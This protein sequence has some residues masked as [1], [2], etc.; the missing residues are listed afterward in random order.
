MARGIPIPYEQL[1]RTATN[2][3]GFQK[4]AGIEGLNTNNSASIQAAGNVAQ[5]D[6]RGFVVAEQQVGS[7]GKAIAGEGQAIMAIRL[8]QNEAINIRKEYEANTS[9]EMA[10]DAINADLALE[11]D[12]TKWAGIADKHSTRLKDSLLKQDL[13]PDARDAISMKMDSWQRRQSLAVTINSA[14]RS[15][16]KMI[17]AAMAEVTQLVTSENYVLAKTR[18]QNLVDGGWV[19][20]AEAAKQE[21]RM[22]ALA[23]QQKASKTLAFAVNNYGVFSAN[24]DKY[25]EGLDIED[26]L[27]IKSQADQTNRQNIAATTADFS[28]KIARGD[29]KTLGDL[30]TGFPADMKDTTKLEFKNMWGRMNNAEHKAKLLVAVP[31]N[32]ARFK[33]AVSSYDPSTDPGGERYVKIKMGIVETLPTE[34]RSDLITP[35]DRKFGPSWDLQVPEGLSDAMYNITRNIFNNGGFGK[36][37]RF[38]V[39]KDSTGAPRTDWEPKEVEDEKAKNIAYAKRG[40]AEIYMKEWMAKFPN[41]GVFKALD[42]LNQ[43]LNGKTKPVR[44]RVSAYA[45]MLEPTPTPDGSDSTLGTYAVPNNQVLRDNLGFLIGE[46]DQNQPSAFFPGGGGTTLVDE[47]APEPEPDASFGGLPPPKGL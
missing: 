42:E 43:F 29:F 21:A 45:P 39:R 17:D 14:K 11:P 15:N 30:N 25:L 27:A 28:D 38:E 35:L 40:E 32:F 37:K 46:I 2:L 9:M 7:I 10:Q 6:P 13:S 4:S 36:F 33:D 34:L 41:A 20:K 19:P 16:D 1:P 12:E 44:A 22:V 26:K 24:P 47:P 3:G 8:K 18:L 5:V 23:K 31:E